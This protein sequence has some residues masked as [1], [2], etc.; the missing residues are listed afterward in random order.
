MRLTCIQLRDFRAF[1]GEFHLNLPGG[2]NLL[3][4]GENGSGKSSLALAMREF[5]T[6]ERPFPRPIES[7]RHIFPDP[8]STNPRAEFTFTNGAVT[9]SIAWEPGKLHPLELG[10]PPAQ[11]TTTQPQRESLIAVSRRSGFF[12]YR[13]LLR[14][15]LSPKPDELPPQ[16]FRLFVE[17]LLSGFPVRVAGTERTLGQLW[18]E[19]NNTVPLSRH[20]KRIREA[21]YVAQR[22]DNAF[23]P[24]LDQVNQRANEFLN[25]FPNH[26]MKVRFDYAG[27]SFAKQTKALTGTAIYPEIEFNGRKIDRHQEFLNEARLTAMALSAFLAAVSLADADPANP[28]PLRLLV[29]DD[30][31]IGLDLNNRLPLLELLRTQ[32]A[33]YQIVLLTHDQV[34][35]DI[36]REHTAEWGNWRA[37]R[38]HE[39]TAGPNDSI[40]PRLEG[41]MDDLRVA[42]KHCKA[43][44]LKSAAVYIRAAFESRLRNIC[45]NYGIAVAFK[46]NPREVKA[47]K[48]W[49]AIRAR[50]DGRVKEGKGEF[51]D[52]ALFPRIEATRSAVLNRLSH[53]GSS[54]LT[55]SDVEVALQTMQDFR[56]SQVPFKK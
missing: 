47:D 36:A 7:Q 31:L 46:A 37:A 45:E 19:L 10:D 48:L 12:D 52:P 49:E 35:F 56:K 18:I 41:D 24:F 29:L 21:N 28:D 2:C 26:R 30:V 8:A 17:C 14:A 39:E 38:L 23:R 22:F 5:F 4:H 51:V 6:L 50:H 33:H 25:Q 3:V 53:S 34:W 11:P 1:P 16:L 54:S 9:E 27:S 32:F 13:A 42:K 43:N 44:D 20:D 15:S 40:V 55:K